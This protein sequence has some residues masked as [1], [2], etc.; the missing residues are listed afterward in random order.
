[1]LTIPKQLNKC[2]FILT[3][4]NKRPTETGWT[5]TA[6]YDY[7][8]ITKKD[9]TTYGVL[10]GHNKLIVIDVDNLEVQNKLI[11]IEE[12]RNTFTT[13]TAN[14]KL[15]HFYFYTDQE[16]PTT[17]RIDNIRDERIIDVQGKGAM[18]IGPGSNINNI[19]TYEVVNPAEIQTIN[20]EYLKNILINIEPNIKI[21]ERQSTKS[22]LVFPEH[23]EICEAIKEKLSIKDLLPRLGI[24]TNNYQ[25]TNC[26]LGHTSEG[27]QCFSFTKHVWHCFHCEQSGNIFQLYMKT[28]K[29]KFLEARQALA[30]IAGVQQSFKE[31]VKELIRD[32]KT[33]NEGIEKMAREF[34][35]TYHVYTIRHDSS[36]EMFIYKGGVYKPNGESYIHEYV[37]NIITTM[38]T[39]AIADK[40]IEKVIVD[41]YI[42]ETTFYEDTPLNLIPFNNTILD[43]H[44]MK[45][46]DYDPSLRFMNKH[47]VTYDPIKTDY[48]DCKIIRFIKEIVKGDNDV[49]TL[50][51]LCGYIFWRDN[52]FE[53]SIMLLGNGRNGK[54][55][56]IDVLKNMIGHENVVNISLSEIENNNFA[57]SN[58]HKKH[59]N[60]SPDLSKDVLES[61]GKFKSLIGR[62]TITAD[63][64]HKSSIHFKNFAKFVFATNQLP[65]TTDH[66][67]GFFDR[68]LIIDFPYKF[69]DNPVGP[70]QKKKDPNIIDKIL[71]PTELTTFLNWSLE[72]LKRLFDR[73]EFT[74]SD[75]TNDIKAKW[76]RKSSSITGFF[77]EH[78]ER[79]GL[80]ND[81]VTI[82]DFDFAYSD[83]CMT[84][85]L[86]QDTNKVKNERLKQLGASPGTKHNQRGYFG[87]KLLGKYKEA[88]K[89][90]FLEE[91][92]INGS[93]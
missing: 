43:L 58:F 26:P 62:D 71:N 15:Y 29:V 79:T 34:K 70:L 57:M 44:T 55:K 22:K 75:T 92:I 13:K 48:D 91:E 68:W 18:V 52:K 14:K 69:E 20:Y 65:Y 41:T 40:V 63:R 33:R 67:D 86:D 66:S 90:D 59:A 74:I 77:A 23:D 24:K 8:E 30:E 85:V 25:N 4:E 6:N 31:Q 82:S 49:C 88:E 16:E 35:K 72:G 80:R 21:R 3:G 87:I 19:G 17:Y 50:Q 56:F 32:P 46:H 28:K 10:C 47:P 78:V 64:K 36:P 76:F 27:G 54:S 5:T 61:T 51:E 42:D 73:G 11:T 9:L 7:D 60:F 39:N 45:T 84:H 81:F 37:R 53:K 38:Y 93:E 83:Y 1:M 2:R 89:D 12:L